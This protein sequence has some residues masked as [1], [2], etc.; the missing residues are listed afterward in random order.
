MKE[1]DPT[2]DILKFSLHELTRN[3]TAEQITQFSKYCF[4]KV[5]T[6][7]F[8]RYARYPQLNIQI[9]TQ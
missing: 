6:E 7:R 2:V 9:I 4:D 1:N 5:V 8:E 3:W